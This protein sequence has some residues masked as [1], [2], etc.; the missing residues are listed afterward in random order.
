[1]GQREEGVTTES[2]VL[3]VMMPLKSVLSPMHPS[4]LLTATRCPH[5]PGSHLY[6][7]L[8]SSSLKARRSV[9]TWLLPMTGTAAGTQKLDEQSPNR[10]PGSHD[11]TPCSGTSSPPQHTGDNLHTK[12]PQAFLHRARGLYLP[13][14]FCVMPWPPDPPDPRQAPHPWGVLPSLSSHTAHHTPPSFTVPLQRFSPGCVLRASKCPHFPV[15]RICACRERVRL[16]LQLSLHQRWCIS[17]GLCVGASPGFPSKQLS[18]APS[19]AAWQLLTH[20]PWAGP[21]AA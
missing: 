10:T 4:P 18:A 7:T 15:Q 3:Q 20:L 19:P 12:T 16:L 6:P 11:Q 5:L 13:P 14:L 9:W 17:L 2:F 1:M 8:H 21:P